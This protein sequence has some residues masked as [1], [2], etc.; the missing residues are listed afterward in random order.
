LL[1]LESNPFLFKYNLYKLNL[2]MLQ[3]EFLHNVT[4]YENGS[5]AFSAS[6]ILVS[7]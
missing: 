5:E 6:K 1:K 2:M 4:N 3:S 7:L